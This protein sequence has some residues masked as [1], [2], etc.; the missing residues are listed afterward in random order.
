MND[1]DRAL[2]DAHTDSRNEEARLV[3]AV[4]REGDRVNHKWAGKTSAL[5]NTSM[6]PSDDF[7]G[8]VE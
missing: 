2:H 4:V 6:R 1:R 8:T 5:L 7:E 3:R